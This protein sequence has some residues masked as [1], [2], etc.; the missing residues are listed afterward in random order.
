MLLIVRDG[1]FRD[2]HYPLGKPARALRLTLGNLSNT[3]LVALVEKRWDAVAESPTRGA[4]YLELSREGLM[5]LPQATGP[6][7]NPPP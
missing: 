5:S 3:E 6:M 4:C 2:S 7:A 1:D